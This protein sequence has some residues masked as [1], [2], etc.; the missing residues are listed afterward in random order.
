[1]FIRG[2]QVTNFFAIFVHPYYRSG[3]DVGARE[4]GWLHSP[5]TYAV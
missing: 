5:Y 1:M 3:T 2:V 4:I